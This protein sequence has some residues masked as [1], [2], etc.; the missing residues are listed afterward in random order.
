MNRIFRVV[1]SRALGTWVVASELTARRGKSGGEKRHSRA[2][3]ASVS[4]GAL[5]ICGWSAPVG[6]QTWKGT[7]SSDWTV[8]SNWSTGTAPAANATVTINTNSPNPTVLGVSGAATSTIGNLLMS[9]AAGTSALT[10]Q[11]G[12]SLSDTATGST[13]IIGNFAGANATVT[14]TGAGSAWSTAG[15][16]TFG[17]LG[18]GTLNIANGAA[19]SVTNA[20]GVVFGIGGGGSGT[21][22]I[23]SGGTLTASNSSV[24]N[25]AATVS[26]AGSLWNAGTSLSVG[27]SNTGTGAL[28]VQ[29]GGVVTV[30]GNITVGGSSLS[31]RTGVGA[32]TVTDAGS[33][34]SSSA[35]LGIG[36]WG[37]GTLTVS[38]G[39]VAIANTVNMATGGTGNATLNLSSGGTLA[40]QALTAGA[41]TAQ[42]N[43]DS[44]TLRAT[45]SNAAFVSGYTGTE[46]TI[47]AGGFTLDTAGFNVT[48]ASPFSGTGAL[49]KIGTGTAVF[50]GDSA[51]TGGT[52]ISAGTLQL[53]NGGTSGS[54]TGN[55]TNNGTLTFDR[56]DNY[57]FAGLI[58]GSGSLDQAGSGSTILTAAGNSV[59][60]TR[61]DAGILQVNNNSLTSTGG[62]TIN[63]GTLQNAGG[64]STTVTP[65][66]TMNAG[67]TLTIGGGTVEAGGG[68]QTLFTGGTGGA[69]INITG[70]TLFGNGTLGGG[71]NVVNLNGSLNTGAATLNLGSGNDTFLLTGF[72]T[73]VGAG[74]DG[75]GGTNALQVNSNFSRTLDGAS[76]THFQ[77]LS[78]SGT[79]TLTLTGSHSYSAGTTISAGTLQI[80]NGATAGALAT[81]TVTNNGTLAF[82]LNSNYSFAGAIS[83]TGAVNKLGTGITTLTG[84]NSYTGATNI[85]AG[86]LLID[87][88]QSGA[89]GPTNV[90]NGATL[91]GTGIVGGS[92]TVANGGALSPSGAGNA[93]GALT[94][95]GNL[96]LNSGAALNYQFGQAN[97]P[98]GALNDLTT[99]NGNLTLAGT[100]NLSTSSGG[101][102]GPGVYRVFNYAGTLTNNGLSIGSAPAGTYYVQTSIANQVNLVNSTGLTLNFWDGAAGPKDNGVINGGIGTWQNA[103]GNDNWADSTGLVNAP[104]SNGSFAVFEATPGTVTVDNSLGNVS[105]SGMQ[106][107]VDGYT[108]TGN[109]L[110][111]S[112]ATNIIRVGDGTAAGANM[113]ATIDAVLAGTGGVQKTDLGTLVLNGANTYTGGTAIDGGVLQVASDANLGDASG[114]L[115]FDGG[116]LRNTAVFTSARAVTLNTNGG[117]FD[118]QANLT[119]S[120]GIGGAGALSKTSSGT[121]TLAGNN[122]YTGATTVQAGTLLVDGNQSGATGPTTVQSGATLG[123]NGTLGGDVTIVNGGT[124]S[125]GDTGAVGTLTINGNLTLNSGATLN[126][127]FGQAN[128]PGG[129]LNDL[130]VVH[131]NLALAGTLNVSTTSGGSFGPGVYRVFNYAGTLTDNGL[132]LGTTPAANLYVQ[133]SIAH[134]VNLVNSSGLTLNFWDGPG[135]ANDNAVTGG[136]GTWRLADND[137]WTD[138]SGALNAPYSNGAFAV[139][140]G[141]PGTVTIDNSNGQVQAS[142]LQFEVDGYHLTG[143]TL[144]LTGNTPTL[145]VG[146]GTAAGAAMTATIDAVLAGT[147]TLVKDDLG[148]LVLAGNNTYAGGTTV[149]GGTLQ[150][151]SDANLGNTA[152][153]LTLGDGT[154]HTTASF[155]TGRAVNLT[156]N[157]TFQ[158][159]GGTTLA[160]ANAVTGTG[161]LAKTGGGTLVLGAASTYS[162]ATTVTAG[163]LQAAVANAFSGSSAITVTANGRLDLAGFAQNAASL[164]NAGTVHFGSTPGTTLTVQG[165]YAG[166]GGTLNVNT[167]LG[168]DSSSTDQLI[169]H[170]S[171]SGNSV[172]RVANVGGN[173]ALTTQGIKLIDVQGASNGMFSLAG[174]YV[175]QGQQAVVGGAYAYRLYQGGT[176]TPTDGDWYLHSSLLDPPATTPNAPRVITPLYQ[177]GVPL[178]EAYAGMLQQINTLDSLY[179]RVSDRTW[180]GNTPAA[181]S[182][183][184]NDGVW[185][186]VQGA[187]Q[188]YKP[189][190]TT[191]GADY[192]ISTWKTEAGVD[193]RLGDT[194]SGVLVAGAALQA[195]RYQTNVTSVYGTGRI[196]TH[197]YGINTTLTWYGDGGFYV[198]GQWRWTR[199]DSDLYSSSAA[200]VLK[201]GDHGSGYAVGVEAGQ[202]FRLGD[203]WSLIP[204]AQVSYGRAA[205]NAFNDVFGANVS[206][207]KGQDLVG[208]AGIAMDYRSTWQGARGPIDS[209]LYAIA[210]L[211]RDFEGATRVDV[212]GTD[213]IS[214]NERLWGGLGIGGSLDWGRYSIY[215]E[216]RGKTGLSHFGDSHEVTGTLGFRV[217]W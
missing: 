16:L 66:I 193:A 134:Q 205:F 163:T 214:R 63:A 92:V 88:N 98:G 12:S 29:N 181:D 216:V 105:T 173:G 17:N 142:G 46:L 4:V 140:A 49:T 149:Q 184:P 119:L 30:A 20:L 21:L 117:T 123:G 157:S 178:Y 106:F 194:S 70:G 51:Y 213:F 151:S 114:G 144:V 217:K 79:G 211:Y 206:V 128:T 168:G 68:T 186:R 5:L 175:F 136:T 83:G 54:I 96:T 73:I 41:G 34:L 121:L 133:T 108:I 76:V 182:V 85:N 146:D 147:G 198:D 212:S 81:P 204:Q 150:V 195:G 39:A 37:Q 89:T 161:S 101:S 127:Q 126:Y 26:G 115:S 135:H 40:T 129:S 27:T 44:G 197:S 162:G 210:N 208:R 143:G 196:K 148:T 199:F 19:V 171:T 124:L 59:G 14:V 82:N 183:T 130:T 6:A 47:A 56:S 107:A 36:L 86:T 164:T 69:T 169:V 154:L 61:I 131:G 125:P 187:G 158:T 1:W 152:G 57:T 11:N 215:G 200:Q 72:A 113:T 65:T 64:S 102:F 8:G 167:A 10:I 103:S 174:N 84:T 141:T 67:S 53:G 33:Q 78:K 191:S 201:N 24:R 159:D 62:I 55:V 209:H 32:I 38:N 207:Q 71:G 188:T 87:G 75:G 122:S 137:N 145:R 189:E 202:R 165:N 109:A 180:A 93:P 99:V 50:T 35:V 80:G 43:F 112:G 153:A 192:G 60:T 118:T 190:V 31:N 23:T 166:Q 94:I 111:L 116:T 203:A 13:N 45:A 52:T 179:E 42:A 170:G 176:G 100:L 58:S 77:T 97:T 177:P 132:V 28:N 120:G 2:L 185:M 74:V 138:A 7:T 90:A 15:S 22:N 156:G 48:A 160:L 18:T 172:V 3:L 9:S 25:G 95:N 139:F 91:G 104:Y 155:Q 110:T